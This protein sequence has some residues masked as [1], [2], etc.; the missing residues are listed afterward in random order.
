MSYIK[1]TQEQI[2]WLRNNSKGRPLP[3]IHKAFCEL[4]SVE[5]S[6]PN[7][8]AT[9]VR[10]GIRTGVRHSFPST[11][12]EGELYAGGRHIKLNGKQIHIG[13]FLPIR[14]LKQLAK[15]KLKEADPALAK[16]AQCSNIKYRVKADDVIERLA[17][18][19]SS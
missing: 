11:I 6:L 2:E 3:E 5:I 12:A 9:L 19:T 8:R 4:F 18:E 17:N 7:F 1:R 10:Y 13:A 15:Q 14:K 16:K